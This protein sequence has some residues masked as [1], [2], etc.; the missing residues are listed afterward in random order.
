[1]AMSRTRKTV[2][3]ITGIVVALG[4]IVVIGAALILASALFVSP[5]GYLA[6]PALDR[7][8]EAAA[9]ALF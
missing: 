5:L 3:I 1:M 4:V 9:A 8:T 7:A 6:I 2:W